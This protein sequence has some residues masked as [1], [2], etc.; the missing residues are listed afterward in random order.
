MATNDNSNAPDRQTQAE[1]PA[2]A[3]QT[4]EQPRQQSAQPQPQPQ[5][6]L[7]SGTPPDASNTSTAPAAQFTAMSSAKPAPGTMKKGVY[8][9]A[10]IYA[11][12]YAAPTEDFNKSTIAIVKKLIG[13]CL[14]A[15]QDAVT[16]S[17]KSVDVQNDVEQDDGDTSGKDEPPKKGKSKASSTRKKSE[18]KFQF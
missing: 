13:D 1:Q 12:G 15:P 3:G 6:Q 5:L 18:E 14:D 10:L 9:S 8:I 11:E 17:L 2:Q 16:L 4:E 7:Q